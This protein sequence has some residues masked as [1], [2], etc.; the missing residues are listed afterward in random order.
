MNEQIRD[1]EKYNKLK[2]IDAKV[3]SHQEE[4]PNLEAK[5]REIKAQWN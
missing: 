1:N 5:I 3:S 4:I 2:E